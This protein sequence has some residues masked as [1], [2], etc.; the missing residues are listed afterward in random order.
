MSRFLSENKRKSGCPDFSLKT[1]GNPD[2][3][4]SLSKQE[5]IRMS[6]FLSQ[7]KRKSGC[8]DFSL[9]T[10]GNSDVQISLSKLKEIRM[11]R[12]LSQNKIARNR[13]PLWGWPIE[14]VGF[15][16]NAHAKWPE[17]RCAH[18]AGDIAGALESI[19]NFFA[20]GRRRRA[21]RA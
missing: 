21:G 16:G 9:K 12:F 2:V 6:R 3:R 17:W 19:R 20:W 7:N 13:S 8:P 11:F 10:K 5:E 18:L 4:I 1:K 15:A 14:N